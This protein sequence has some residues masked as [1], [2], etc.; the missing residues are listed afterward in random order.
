MRYDST[1][2]RKAAS[3][4]LVGAAFFLVSCQVKTVVEKPSEVIPEKDLYSLAEED[5]QAGRVDEAIRKYQAYVEQNPGSEKSRIAL[6][7]IAKIY[8]DDRLY[9]RALSILERIAEAYPHHFDTPSVKYDIARIHNLLGDFEAS[10]SACLEWLQAFPEDPLRGDIMFLLGNDYAELG[11]RSQT[12]LWWL[13][14]EGNP[15]I[16]DDSLYSREKIHSG[17]VGLIESARIEDLQEMAE[18]GIDSRYIP[19]IYNRM[20]T[21][22]LDEDRL[23]E[24]KKYAMLLV[25]S[26][27]EDHWVSIGR[28]FLEVI[29]EKMEDRAEFRSGVIGCLLPLTGPYALYGEELLNGIQMGMGVFQQLPGGQGLELI[30]RDTKG[31]V[32]DTVEQVEELA[33]KEKV[34][35]IIGPLASGPATA[36]V[37]KAQELGV[38]IITFAQKDGITREGDMV[39]RNFLTP[40]KEVETILSRAMN[41]LGMR[42]FAIFYP[43]NPYGK[44]FMNLFWDR[45]EEMGGE[46]TAVESYPEDETDFAVSIKKMVGLYYPRPE[47]VVRMLEE[48]KK[49]SSQETL[50]DNLMQDEDMDVVKKG[51]K[52][53]T[54]VDQDKEEEP[55]PIVD[56]DAVF[57]PDNYQHIALIAPQFPYY[58]VFNVPFLGTSQW[59]S[60]ELIETTGDYIQGAVFPS[61]FYIENESEAVQGFVQ[62]YRANFDSTPGILAANGYDT[63]RF[64]KE[65]I[66]RGSIKSRKDFQRMLFNDDSFYGVTGKISFD[67]QGEVQKNPLLLTVYGKKIHLLH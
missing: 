11:N 35:A 2:F 13:R 25:R 10:R 65:I 14:T 38:P 20:T 18:Y 23:E 41:E 53:K 24:A 22:F 59:L 32:E 37:R 60:D 45:V 33:H 66:N 12:F 27:R 17:I 29:L 57:I 47:S 40:S 15:P 28:D 63:I 7:R 42:R 1:L 51:D 8:L 54:G 56:F 30:I 48:M 31:R 52:E 49:K 39:F 21:I 4:L 6:N 5:L 46:I 61:G 64:L 16:R 55:E 19:D 9:N 36:A 62:A 58:N 67:Q 43:D 34:M 44:F 26:S 3:I 50:E